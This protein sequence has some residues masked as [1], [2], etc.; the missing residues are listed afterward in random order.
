[1]DLR[2]ELRFDADPA[3]VFAMF[4]DEMYVGRKAKAA[5]AVRHEVSID[6]DG[7]RFTVRLLR[8]MPPDVPDFIRRFVGDSIDLAQT[9]R[10]EPASSD[11]ARDGSIHI[12]M[13]GQPVT[14]NGTMALRPNSHGSITTVQGTI[15]ASVPFVGG[16]IERAVHG[17]LVEAARI[18]QQVG[19]DWLT[20][21]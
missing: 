3:S 20:R 13:V 9:E 14:F 18:E 6:R 17:A 1:M 11:G 7:D 5:N 2:T 8:V 4:T 16:R 10:W 19:R 12:E 21:T 15:K